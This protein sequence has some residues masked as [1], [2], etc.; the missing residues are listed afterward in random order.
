MVPSPTRRQ[1][2]AGLGSV[3]GL[4]A[5]GSVAYHT[6]TGPVG[7][8]ILNFERSQFTVDV[9]VSG[10]DGVVAA[11]TYDVPASAPVEHYSEGSSEIPSSRGGEAGIVRD[12]IINR[13]TRGTT[14]TVRASTADGT[15]TLDEAGENTATVTCT[16]Y[17]NM[18]EERMRDELLLEF[19]ASSSVGGIGLYPNYCGSLW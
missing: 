15:Y 5:V 1:F 17:V 16:G 6:Y 14:Y 7:L 12:R 3:T 4:G 18:S 11:E 19:P 8:T 13:A 2:L 9:Q 10:P